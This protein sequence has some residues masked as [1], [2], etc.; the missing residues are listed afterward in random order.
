MNKREKRKLFGMFNTKEEKEEPKQE[1]K[2]E[3]DTTSKSL[4]PE[5]NEDLEESTDEGEEMEGQL[6]LDMYQTKDNLVVKSTIAGVRPEDIDVTVND[7]VLTISGERMQQ[8]EVREKD[9]YMQECYWGEFSR[10]VELPEEF[11]AEGISA[12]IKDGILTVNI[13]KSEKAKPKKIMVK[14]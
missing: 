8:D 10:S 7:N 14:G 13:P 11:D 3:D 5:E 12:E 4:Q 9:Y 1:K 2:M 6:A